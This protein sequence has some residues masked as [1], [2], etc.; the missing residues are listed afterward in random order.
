MDLSIRVIITDFFQIK[1]SE[2]TYLSAKI[3][4]LYKQLRNYGLIIVYIHMNLLSVSY[5][6]SY[7]IFAYKGTNQM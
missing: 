7:R 6:F 3:D 5:Q 4:Y 2:G 1:E